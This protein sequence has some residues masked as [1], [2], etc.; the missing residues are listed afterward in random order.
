MKDVSKMPVG[1]PDSSLRNSTRKT[2]PK[3]YKPSKFGEI[4]RS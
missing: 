4:L 1:A 2:N 3:K